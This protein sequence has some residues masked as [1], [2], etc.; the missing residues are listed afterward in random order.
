MLQAA[1]VACWMRR[2]HSRSGL[3]VMTAALLLSTASHACFAQSATPGSTISLDTIVVEQK[4]EPLRSPSRTRT[5]APARRRGAGDDQ[6]ARTGGRHRAQALRS[7]ARRRRAG[8]AAGHGQSRQSDAGQQPERCPRTDRAEFPGLQRPAA[9]PDARGR[10]A[11][12]G[13]A[14]RADTQQRFA[15][16]SR[17]RLL[18]HRLRQSATGRIDRSVSRLHG[19]SP[20][21][22]AC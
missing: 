12:S 1:V 2:G 19:Q 6:R 11:E 3:R 15:D 10:T 17:R 14:R 16:Q 18:H 5:Q 13:R 22:H 4:R 8:V 7:S 21:R 20:R 9:D